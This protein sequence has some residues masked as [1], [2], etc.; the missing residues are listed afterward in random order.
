M[1]FG[2]HEERL[3]Q[4]TA[5]IEGIGPVI[6]EKIQKGGVR[7]TETLLIR[8]GNAKGRKTLAISH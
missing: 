8:G 2:Y 7:P 6:A 3:R 4:E 1:T 5:E